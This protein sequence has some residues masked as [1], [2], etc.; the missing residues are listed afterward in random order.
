MSWLWIIAAYLLGLG[1]MMLAVAFGR[2]AAED[3]HPELLERAL[4]EARRLQVQNDE[5]QQQVEQ[6]GA[7]RRQA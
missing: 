3:P 1:T 4:E 2:S 5:L 7:G 6:L